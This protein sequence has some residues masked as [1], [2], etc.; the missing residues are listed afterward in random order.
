MEVGLE[1]NLKNH[2]VLT[3]NLFTGDI[4]YTLI[5]KKPEITSYNNFNL[6]NGGQHTWS[7]R[8]QDAIISRLAKNSNIDRMGYEP[9]IVYLNGAY[10]G[11]YGIREK[12]DEQCRE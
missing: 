8:I 3:L 12:I 5:K 6:R 10:W 7:D 2:F 9:C 11:L 1:Q 4:D